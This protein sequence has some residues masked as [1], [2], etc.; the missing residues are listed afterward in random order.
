MLYIDIRYFKNYLFM[1]STNHV[2]A[3]LYM[4]RPVITKSA[5]QIQGR[6][7]ALNSDDCPGISVGV[8]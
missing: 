6:V 7:V 3:H 4:L 5:S 1:L 8:E 2:L